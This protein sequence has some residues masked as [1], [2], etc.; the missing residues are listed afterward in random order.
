MQFGDAAGRV[1]A[2]AVAWARLQDVIAAA[3]GGG[4]VVCEDVVVAEDVACTG[5]FDRQP[6]VPAVMRS[7]RP[8][9]RLG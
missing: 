2:G 3:S 6:R 9:R 5:E 7:G 4:V 8:T 1:G